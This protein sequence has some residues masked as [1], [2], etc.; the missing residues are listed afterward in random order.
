MGICGLCSFF[1]Y[2]LAIIQVVL[3]WQWVVGLKPASSLPAAAAYR[4]AYVCS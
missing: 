2:G 3:T 4:E 1:R